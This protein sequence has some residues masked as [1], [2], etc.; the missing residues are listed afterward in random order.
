[1]DCIY[2][3]NV[4]GT[5]YGYRVAARVM[6]DSGGGRI[7]GACSTSGKITY[8]TFGIYS[9]SKAAVRSLTQTAAQEWGPFGITVNAYAPGAVDTP[10]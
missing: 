2:S 5:F 9:M 10:M 3:V 1:M 8:P 6:K 7:I 4:K